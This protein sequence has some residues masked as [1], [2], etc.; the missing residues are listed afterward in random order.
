MNPTFESIEQPTLLLDEAAAR[1]NIRFMA[2]KATRLGLVFRPHFKTHQSA[3]IGEWFREQGVSKITVSSVDMAEYFAD[4]GWQDIVIAFSLNLRQLERIK[5]LARRVHLGILVENVDAIGALQ[6]TTDTRLDVW[7]KIDVGAKR[8]GL[9]WQDTATTASLCKMVN[10]K[11][12]FHLRGLLTHSGHTYAARSRAE[13]LELFSETLLRMHHLK[14]ELAELGIEPLEISVGDTPGCT[15]AEN[16]ED[17][18]EIRPGNFVFYD[19]HQL[20]IGVCNFRDIA[21]A[22]ACPVVAIHPEREEMVIYGGAVHLSKESIGWQGVD[23]YG[24]VS[25]PEGQ[26]WSNPVP[27]AY[28]ARLSQEHGI[29]HYPPGAMKNYPIRVGDLAIVI[30]AHSCL[31]VQAMGQYRTLEGYKI[32]TMP[33]PYSTSIESGIHSI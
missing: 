5:A 30:P 17:A 19:V 3:V 15:L 6:E 10:Q 2:E 33:Q 26:G 14:E 32:R 21:V 13:V 29:L 31:A 28:V 24:L 7:L 12:A 20:S 9:D 4:N 22:V 11:P 25:V 23:T 1:R 8:T 27:D 16:F 18:D